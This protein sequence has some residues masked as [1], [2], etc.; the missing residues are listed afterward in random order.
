MDTIISYGAASKAA[1]TIT[2]PTTLTSTETDLF[3]HVGT[4][5]LRYSQFTIY[6]GVTL[7]GVT[8]STF[9]YYVSPNA[10]DASPVWY[11]ISL[12]ATSTGEITQRAV[13]V[14]SGT[15]VIGGVSQ[16]CDNLPVPACV[17]FKITGKSSSGTPTLALSVMTRNN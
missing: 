8:S 9:Y 11:P 13:L 17:G 16:F 15:Y 3:I 10:S 4:G 2:I 7:G 1:S 12:Y 5:I 14:D 6:A